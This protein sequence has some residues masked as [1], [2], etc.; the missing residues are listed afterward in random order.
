MV[1][2]IGGGAQLS[3]NTSSGV[4][5]GDRINKVGGGGISFGAVNLPGQGMSMPAWAWA[6]LAL[7][8]ALLIGLAF[9]KK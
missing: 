7:L 1:P 2:G 8:A 6:L 9:K 4:S 5:S 3:Q